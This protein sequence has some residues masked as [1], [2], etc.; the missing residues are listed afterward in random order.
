MDVDSVRPAS[1]SFSSSNSGG[2]ELKRSLLLPVWIADRRPRVSAFLA[3]AAFSCTL[4]SS[5]S[6]AQNANEK[7][8]ASPGDAVLA[9]YKAAKSDDKNT[10]NA[11]FGS[12]SANILHSG[13]DVADKNAV[14]RFVAN[15]DAM[16]RIVIEP[17]QT[18]TLYVG[19]ENWPMPISLV[20]NSSGAWYFD[21]EA[22]IKEILYRRIG[23]N[24][25]DAIDVLHALIA[26][27]KEYAST[28]HDDQKVKQYAGKVFS[29]DGK[30]NGLYWKTSD[31][32]TPSPIG[33]LLAE[34]AGEGYTR[35][36]DQPKAFHGYIYRMLS[37]QGAAAKGGARSYV[38]DGK[39]TKGV[40]FI[41]YP[42]E[43]RNS[44]V[45]TF[46]VNQDDAVY[47]ADLGPDTA[48]QAATMTEF[49][50]D[51]AWVHAD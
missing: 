44:G 2:F 1:N 12:N 47:Q 6:P 26:A 16:H 28:T 15:Y 3:L 35:K 10:L 18:A 41:A 39:W 4:L 11:I 32:E 37:G 45:M 38:A 22:G 25:T 48:K 50:P 49:N 7:T 42:A 34:A 21:T 13:D 29:D 8:F 43:Y 27:Q 23:A 33:P 17:D 31:N 5:I 30:H 46:I 19:A 14:S 9:V 24:E 20:K 40:A 36:D 51:S